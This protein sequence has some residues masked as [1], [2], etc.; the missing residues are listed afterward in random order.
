MPAQANEAV[1]AQGGGPEARA[2]MRQRI[3]GSG[4]P[5]LLKGL[6]QPAERVNISEAQRVWCYLQLVSWRDGAS[7]PRVWV[8]G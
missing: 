1:A 5:L 7:L 4:V 3:E 6:V 2:R 8:Y